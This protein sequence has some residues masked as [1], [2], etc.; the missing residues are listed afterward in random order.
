[1]GPAPDRELDAIDRFLVALDERFDA[2]VLEVPHVAV[3]ALRRAARLAHEQ[4]N[5]TL[6][7]ATES[8]TGARR[9]WNSG[10][11][12]AFVVQRFGITTQDAVRMSRASSHGESRVRRLSSSPRPAMRAI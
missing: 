4:R 3:H 12:A 5:P 9:S 7:H 2:P 10:L 1:M 8:G 11:C 6:A